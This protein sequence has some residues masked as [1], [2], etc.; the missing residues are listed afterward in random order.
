MEYEL[1]IIKY[2]TEHEIINIYYQ[3]YVQWTSNCFGENKLTLNLTVIFFLVKVFQK[4]L[5]LVLFADYC[6]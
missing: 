2:I 5:D 3:I 1:L 4:R 6:K